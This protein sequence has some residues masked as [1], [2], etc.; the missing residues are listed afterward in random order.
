M[1]LIL[2]LIVLAGLFPINSFAD[3]LVCNLKVQTVNDTQ[4]DG[5]GSDSLPVTM[6]L[7]VG[8][9]NCIAHVDDFNVF[10][11]TLK[12][13]DTGRASIN[14]KGDSSVQLSIFDNYGELESFAT[15]GC[16]FR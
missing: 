11:I 12:D 7:S 3:Y 6:N 5:S 9:F 10:R 16:D 15:C 14:Y 1:K 4:G 2:S 8:T 13:S